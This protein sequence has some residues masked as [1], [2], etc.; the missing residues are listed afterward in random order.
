MPPD[1]RL[2]QLSYLQGVN[3]PLIGPLPLLIQELPQLLD[4]A[5]GADGWREPDWLAGKSSV[6]GISS[7]PFS[8]RSTTCSPCDDNCSC[9]K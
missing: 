7:M 2:A 8:Y 1:V 9:K 3:P 5:F 6:G 4:E